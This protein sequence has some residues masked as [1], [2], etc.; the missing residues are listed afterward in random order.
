MLTTVGELANV[1][2][3]GGR[4]FTAV[5]LPYSTLVSLVVS[6]WCYSLHHLPFNILWYL[7]CGLVLFLSPHPLPSFMR[8]NSVMLFRTW[9]LLYRECH[10]AVSSEAG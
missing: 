7:V 2:S 5:G 10:L 9:L 6:S 4:S 1:T 3:C 8:Y